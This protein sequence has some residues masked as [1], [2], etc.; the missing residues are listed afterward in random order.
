MLFAR[1][2][3]NCLSGLFN[4]PPRILVNIYRDALYLNLEI[5]FAEIQNL[6]SLAIWT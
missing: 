6:C 4:I 1:A 2:Q 5:R 3:S